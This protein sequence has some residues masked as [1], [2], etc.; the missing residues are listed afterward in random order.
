MTAR[1]VLRYLHL[2]CAGALGTLVYS[3][4]ISNESFLFFNQVVTVPVLAA[5]GLWMWLGPRIRTHR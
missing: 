3:P 1:R 2:L 4:W 5:S